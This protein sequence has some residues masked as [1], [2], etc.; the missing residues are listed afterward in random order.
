MIGLSIALG[1]NVVHLVG[2]W[3]FY[4]AIWDFIQE[5]YTETLDQTKETDWDAFD[6]VHY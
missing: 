1:Y 6:D 2:Q 3:F 4:G 5:N